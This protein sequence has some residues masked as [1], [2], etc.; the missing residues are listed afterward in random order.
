MTA[1]VS[2]FPSSDATGEPTI[3]PMPGTT[4]GLLNVPGLPLGPKHRAFDTP[5]VP[6]KYQLTSHLTLHEVKAVLPSKQLR[7]RSFRVA[8]GS[9]LLIG[10]LARLDVI[11][12][13]SSTIYITVFVSH[14]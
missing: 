3:A 13:P 1:D 6:H 11:S 4:L 7:G 9:T 5:G 14:L 10:G 12:T 8:A 2:L